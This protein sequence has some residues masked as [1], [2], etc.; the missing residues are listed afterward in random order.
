MYTVFSKRRWQDSPSSLNTLSLIT[1]LLIVIRI[2]LLWVW[3]YCF[4][5]IPRKPCMNIYVYT[6]WYHVTW[7][8][9]CPIE[10]ESCDP[11]VVAVFS[12]VLLIVAGVYGILWV[13]RAD[14]RRAEVNINKSNDVITGLASISCVWVLL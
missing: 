4:N 3:S 12:T 9:P 10:N 8:I 1:T 6:L 5:A 2:M 7:T 14:S 11:S 13:W